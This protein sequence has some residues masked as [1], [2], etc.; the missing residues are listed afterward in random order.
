MDLQFGPIQISSAQPA[1]C[2][3]YDAW[4]D[5]NAIGYALISLKDDL[6]KNLSDLLIHFG[7]S[8]YGKNDES[9]RCARILPLLR[10]GVCPLFFCL[11]KH[12]E[13]SVVHESTCISSIA[14]TPGPGLKTTS[15]FF[16]RI[17]TIVSLTVVT[18][19]PS[20]VCCRK[21]IGLYTAPYLIFRRNWIL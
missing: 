21:L 5:Q 17:R 14:P 9:I 15:L 1:I 16:S 3:V 2:S 19:E 7:N 4:I 18:S 11:V 8:I 20:I 10:I 13:Y 12:L 6:D